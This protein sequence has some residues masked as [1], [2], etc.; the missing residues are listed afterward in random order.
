MTSQFAV[1]LTIDDAI[2]ERKRQERAA[3]RST[4]DQ[5]R[6]RKAATAGSPLLPLESTEAETGEVNHG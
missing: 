1:Q 6:Q 2:R 4:R 3:T 5:H